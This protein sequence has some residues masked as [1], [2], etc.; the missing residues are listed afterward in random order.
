MAKTSLIDFQDGPNSFGEFV[1]YYNVMTACPISDTIT[2]MPLAE[3][4]DANIGIGID[5]YHASAWLGSI[6]D[7]HFLLSNAFTT[8]KF[9]L[10]N[11]CKVSGLKIN[12]VINDK[13]NIGNE[14]LV[15]RV[16]WN[17]E[18]Y[19][20][21]VAASL[22][23][24]D[25][26]K[27]LLGLLSQVIHDY[28]E[29][30]ATLML[31]ACH[32]GF[33]TKKLTMKPSVHN[34]LDYP[35]E[36]SSSIDALLKS[37]SASSTGNQGRLNLLL[38]EPGTGKTTLVKTICSLP[39]VTVLN[40]PSGMA[41]RLSDPNFIPVLVEK[42]KH[43]K[44]FI[45]VIEDGD[46]LIV[47]RHSDNNDFAS[48]LLNFTSGIIGDSLNVKVVVTA[49]TKRNE[50]DKAFLRF[51]RLGNIIDIPAF[52]EEE[53]K[54]WASRNSLPTETINGPQTLAE[55]YGLMDSNGDDSEEYSKKSNTKKIGF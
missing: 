25:K 10:E 34:E 23:H 53:A 21:S 18:N 41:G 54:L 7:P 38:G 17:E 47:K 40:V 48:T 26:V 50:L 49:N 30:P 43:C 37:L 55:L 12:F 19:T 51:G 45:I 2:R 29:G 15:I 16:R 39:D 33:D 8:A 4:L 27:P 22:Q 35:K 36:C 9:D 14:N 42:A 13:I 31:V 28:V 20:V 3:G 1:E 6:T 32:G 11:L 24:P 44:I 5:E 46:S 52:P